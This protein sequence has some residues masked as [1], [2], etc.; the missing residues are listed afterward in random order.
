MAAMAAK[1]ADK[2][3]RCAELSRRFDAV[4]LEST[5]ACTDDADCAS[6]GAGIGENCGGATDKTSADELRGIAD[7][8]HGALGCDYTVHC[9]PRLVYGIECRDG[10]CV[11]INEQR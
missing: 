6:Y 9:A 11:E 2:Q 3:A 10:L 5:G 8:F 1:E 7:E 4:L